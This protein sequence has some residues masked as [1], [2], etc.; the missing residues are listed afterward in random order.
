MIKVNGTNFEI[1]NLDTNDSIISRIA[2]NLDTLPKYLKFS[3][4]Y[5]N[6]IKN[7]DEIKVDDTIKIIKNYASKSTA[8]IEDFNQFLEKKLISPDLNISKEILPLWFEYNPKIIQLIK[9]PMTEKTLGADKYVQYKYFQNIKDF[10][11]FLD[12]RKFSIEQI[13]Q[14][15]Q[16]NKLEN[17]KYRDLYEK[18][19]K[20]KSVYISTPFK[21]EKTMIDLTLDLQEITLL[22]IFNHL[23][24]NDNIPF[25]TCQNY[26]KILK[27]YVPPENWT[28]SPDTQIL[29][30]MY[31]KQELDLSKYTNYT[32]VKI[33]M[34]ED[35]VHVLMNLISEKGYLSKEEFIQNFIK[36]F[37][38]LGDVPIQ[39]VKQSGVV[40]LFYFPNK[41]LHTYVFSDL[42]MNDTMF[43]K[44]INIDESRKATKKKTEYSQPWIYIHFTHPNTGNI[45]A[46]I[47]QQFVDRSLPSMQI[48]D[49]KEFQHNQPY[50]R[51]RITHAEDTKSV[52]FFQMILSKLFSIYDSKYDS[53]VSA[54]EKF[55][56]DFNDVVDIEH[57]LPKKQK[58]EIFVT[59]FSRRCKDERRP[60][61][62]DEQEAKKLIEQN[63]KVILFPRDKQD[64]P[65][66]YETDG[67]NQKYYKCENPLFPFPGLQK[68][69]LENK[70]MYPYLP[71]CF[72]ENQENSDYYKEYFLNQKKENPDKKQQD[73]IITDKFL[74]TDT[75]GTLPINLEQLFNILDPSTE[76]R[77]LRLG[78]SK[79]INSFLAAVM[80]GCYNKPPHILNY[81]NHKEREK[82]LLQIKN[83]LQ[84]FSPLARQ[85]MYDFTNEQ[86]VENITQNETYFNPIF[87]IPL[88]ESYFDCNI[89]LFRRQDENTIPIL[90]RH[91]QSYYRYERNDQQSIFLYEHMGSESDNS[92]YPRC[93]LIIKSKIKTTDTEYFFTPDSTV[94][95]GV[96]NIFKLLNKSYVLNKQIHEIKFPILSDSVTLLS[97]SIDSY[98]KTRRIDIQYKNKN[99]TI[100]TNPIPPINIPENSNSIIHKLDIKT[101][102][103]LLETLGASLNSRNAKE[104][105]AMLGNIQISIPHEPYRLSETPSRLSE[106]PFNNSEIHFSERDDSLLQIYNNNKKMARYVTEYLFWTFS[107]YIH[108][109][110]ISKINDTVLYDFSNS[111]IVMKPNFKYTIVPKTFSINS[112]LME[113]NKLIISS[114]EML[115][116]LMYI[117]KLHTTTDLASIQNYYKRNV[118]SNYYTDITDFQYFPNQV[119]LKGEDSVEKW[120][121]ESNVSFNIHD[122]ILIRNSPYFFKN[123]ILGNQIFLA[124]NSNTL[125]KALSIAVNWQNNG[126]NNTNSFTNDINY[127]FTIYFYYSP[128]RI[129]KKQV[130][131]NKKPNKDILI[132]ISHKTLYITLLSL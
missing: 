58:D 109:Q 132:M 14:K 121:Q 126:Y 96:K 116:R 63:K 19:E 32:D 102:L 82:Q 23:L 25:A 130:V 49:P 67:K 85:C 83:D 92:K 119:I 111:R 78:V 4:D 18:F 80:V 43:S 112:T 55:I 73:I 98:G 10:S 87:Y 51:V 11:T 110:K 38:G 34:K 68:N 120:I 86:I 3:G 24:L 88:L 76:Y 131:G 46:S 75:F 26:Y 13:K 30:K 5:P 35:K 56:P 62:I 64:Q 81:K 33:E 2:A 48:E 41:R 115:K 77:Y 57:P 129:I 17:S 60:I 118:I 125:E 45:T 93:E 59:N 79:D 29:L 122:S 114:E 7:G 100:F 21:T 107:N 36:V 6:N 31:E 40:G 70:E 42:V 127:E 9:M 97:Q 39:N 99:A 117:L 124:Q 47:T 91:S 94:S 50:I 15:I 27:N 113:N 128:T 16:L 22:E 12:S 69:N 53:I 103:E 44:L 52:E 61:P 66:L 74:D 95:K 89:F 84:N 8:S 72:Q 71:C 28:S 104:I 105:T 101:T 37:H 108:T 90:P 54:Y 20:I 65:P 1:Y 123:S 106:I